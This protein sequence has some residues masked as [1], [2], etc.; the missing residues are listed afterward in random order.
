MHQQTQTRFQTQFMPLIVTAQ[1]QMHQPISIQRPTRAI[2]GQQC[3]EIEQLA[4]IHQL[5]V[6]FVFQMA[7]FSGYRLYQ[8]Q[9]YDWVFMNVREHPLL[10][11][12]GKLP[13]PRRIIKQINY[14]KRFVDFD[15]IYIAE[16]VEKGAISPWGPLTADQLTPPPSRYLVET[17]DK[18]GSASQSW[19]QI[20]TSPWALLA[21]VVALAPFALPVMVGLDP[22]LFGIRTGTGDLRTGAPAACFYLGHWAWNQE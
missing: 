3:T 5:P 16:E 8:G 19:W 17:A 11:E 14:I 2:L 4:E 21:G 20:L 10:Q 18:F 7:V 13:V 6:H 1:A 12:Q 15:A 9:Q 22:I